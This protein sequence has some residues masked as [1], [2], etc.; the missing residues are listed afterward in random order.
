MPADRPQERPQ[1]PPAPP[2]AAA[3]RRLAVQVGVLFGVDVRPSRVFVWLGGR[4]PGEEA[5]LPLGG[6]P[7]L[8]RR[9]LA[10]KTTHIGPLEVTYAGSPAVT[11]PLSAGRAV[12]QALRARRARRTP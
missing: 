2:N 8:P 11:L 4:R 9:P 12:R 6:A 1:T 7:A 5:I 3:E 10:E